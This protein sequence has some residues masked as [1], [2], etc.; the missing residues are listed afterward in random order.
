MKDKEFCLKIVE[1]VK[2]GIPPDTGVEYYSVGYDDFL[3]D[4]KKNHLSKIGIMGKIRFVC[5]EWG[6]GKTHLFKLIRNASFEENCVVSIVDLYKEEAPLDRF[7]KV[8][9]K[10]LRNMSTR[11]YIENNKENSIYFLLE[12]GLYNMCNRRSGKISYEN[13]SFAVDKLMKNKKIDIDFK[14]IVKSFWETYTKNLDDVILEQEREE[15]L[16]WFSA[17]AD[18]KFFKNKIGVSK[19]IKKENS[20]LILE[21][22]VEFVKLIGYN[23]IVILLDE[24]EQ[25][26]S[27]MKTAN[28]KY[29]HNNLLSLINTIENVPGLFMIYA[30]TP[31]FY[32][33]PKYGILNYG[34]LSERI[35]QPKEIH[36][37]AIDLIW[38]LDAIK[39][40]KEKYEKIALKLMNIYI[41]A[42]PE[43]KKHISEIKIKK[44]IDDFIDNNK[45]F[46]H[47]SRSLRKFVKELIE[48]FDHINDKEYF[49]KTVK[50][51]ERF[52]QLNDD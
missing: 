45:L 14:K 7:E 41:I 44:F 19:I 21:S 2:K 29:A 16:Q 40:D 36:P 12:K 8:F 50:D 18:I 17:D 22:L 15:I 38:N 9:F 28:L 1:E 20:K 49:R 24:S 26:Y 52:V 25:S 39:L 27:I 23:G 43:R 4:L 5:G 46:Y 37:N 48:Y 51:K 35:G 31:D 10:I 34:A 30:T 6:S 3:E 47:Y 11:E 33:H 32:N 13:F 42:Y